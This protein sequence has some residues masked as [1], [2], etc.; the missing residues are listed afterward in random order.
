M[1]ITIKT[2]LDTGTCPDPW[3]GIHECEA[4]YRV[5]IQESECDLA[6]YSL[7]DGNLKLCFKSLDPPN[8]NDEL[9]VVVEN[10]AEQRGFYVYENR[11]ESHPM[12]DL[13]VV[14]INKVKAKDGEVIAECGEYV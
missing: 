7:R 9:I 5:S 3:I 1:S 8:I 2:V 6:Y 10:I 14:G 13:L 11:D 12:V 4:G